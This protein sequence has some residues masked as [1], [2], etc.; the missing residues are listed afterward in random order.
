[1]IAP[2]ISCIVPVHNG[3]R[4]LGEALESILAQTYG[5]VEIIAVDDGS[6]DATRTI[7]ETYGERVRYVWQANAGPATARNTGIRLARGQFI[8]FLDSDDLWHPE[9]LARQMARFDASAPLGL[10]LTRI[11]NFWMPEVAHEEAAFHDHQ[12]SRAIDGYTSVT[13]L[14]RRSVF[15]TIGVFDASLKH[16]DDTDWF[17]RADARQVPLEIVPEVLVRRRLHASN[18]SRRWATRSREEYL[19]MMKKVVD[20]RRATG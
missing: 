16:G 15:E 9:K 6:T 18:R 3:E 17:L 8:S 7:L 11:Q 5:R 12:R 1:M 2:L 10:C 4:F 13:L 20:R 14:A 19:L